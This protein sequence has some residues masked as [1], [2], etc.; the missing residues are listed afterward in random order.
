M[1]YKQGSCFKATSKGKWRLSWLFFFF[2]IKCML[3][4]YD[5]QYYWSGWS[6]VISRII[7]VKIGFSSWSQRLRP[8]TINET[9]IILDIMKT[10][11]NDWFIIHWLKK[12]GSHVSG[13]VF[14]EGNWPKAYE[15]FDLKKSCNA[16][17]HGMITCNLKCPW[18][19]YCI[20]CR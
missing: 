11:S 7:K 13:S 4:L 20:I 2:I 10:Q 6:F 8:L 18:H 14:T 5:K 9:L 15:L 19:G 1:I 3:I 16:V 12:K 17:I